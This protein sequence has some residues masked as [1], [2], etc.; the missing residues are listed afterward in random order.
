TTPCDL[1]DFAVGFSFAQDIIDN[2]DQIYNLQVNEQPNGYEI[3]IDISSEKMQALKSYRR[4][5]IGNTGCGLCGVD[6]LAT[7]IRP[8]KQVP[9]A[10]LPNPDAIQL[11]VDSV[12]DW[13]RIQQLTGACHAAVWC[14]SQGSKILLREDVGRHNAFD[15]LIGAMVLNKISSRD[16][17]VLVSSR[18][19]Y[20]MVHKASFLRCSN[21]V[22]VSAPTSLAIAQAV[23]LNI[24]L[25][26]FARNG[27]FNIY[28]STEQL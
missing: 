23:E 25:I 19:S 14:D 15:K 8:G 18:A 22:A 21:L 4:T 1:E 27:K 16:G 13:Q 24:N 2:I 7:A 6:S 10:P 12:N 26:G 17:F 3:N 20:E 28:H 5:L 11:A 9:K